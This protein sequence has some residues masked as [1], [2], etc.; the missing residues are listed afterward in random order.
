MDVTDEEDIEAEKNRM[1]RI[2]WTEPMSNDDF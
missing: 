1:L 2:A